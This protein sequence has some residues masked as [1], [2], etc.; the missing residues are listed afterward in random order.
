M[1]DHHDH[2]ELSGQPAASPT[3]MKQVTEIVLRPR[4]LAGH[5]EYYIIFKLL[6]I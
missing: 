5:S 6:H 1:D 2:E 3:H 4:P